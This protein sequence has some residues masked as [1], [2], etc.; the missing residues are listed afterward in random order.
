VP[1]TDQEAIRRPKRALERIEIKRQN[2]IKSLDLDFASLNCLY[3]G[4]IDLIPELMTK[5][6]TEL[7]KIKNLGQK[8]LQ[9]IKNALHKKGLKLETMTIEEIKQEENERIMKPVIINE[10]INELKEKIRRLKVSKN[11]SREKIKVTEKG[12]DI[13]QR[14]GP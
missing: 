6:E 3:S 9:N 5:T 8:R 14:K 7:L 10:R 2:S 1:K 12:K 11:L 4:G 13:G